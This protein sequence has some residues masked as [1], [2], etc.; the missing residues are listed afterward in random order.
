MWHVIRVTEDLEKES[1][2]LHVVNTT[3]N[4]TLVDRGR[5]ADTVWTRFKGLIGVRAFAQGDGLAIMPCNGV[6]CMFMSIPIDVLYVSADHRVVALDP[7]M[8]P[9]AIGRFYRGVQY[10][11]E[12]PAGTIRRTATAAGDRLAV[13]VT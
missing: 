1:R 9:W 4:I 6:H 7:E 13:T 3:R 10:V 12:L 5:V 8:R 2:V 11:I